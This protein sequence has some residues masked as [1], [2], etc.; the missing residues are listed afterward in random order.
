M[1]FDELQSELQDLYEEIPG[2]KS[3]VIAPMGANSVRGSAIAVSA[4]EKR[5]LSTK[6]RSV[7]GIEIDVEAI[8]FHLWVSTFSSPAEVRAQTLI[9]ESDG[10]Q[11]V[12]VTATLEMAGTRYRCDCI[13][14]FGQP[15][16]E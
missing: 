4:S 1:D 6:D 5:P 13:R 14:N 9:T 3:V 16:D 2:I 11:W 10:T 7:S 8:Q 12:V 15:D